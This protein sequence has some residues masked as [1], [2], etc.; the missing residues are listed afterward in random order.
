MCRKEEKGVSREKAG[1]KEVLETVVG[2]CSLLV[3]CCGYE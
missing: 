2:V 3:C 1:R